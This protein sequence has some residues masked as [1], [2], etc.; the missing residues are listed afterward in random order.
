[1]DYK[2]K[3]KS[4]FQFNFKTLDDVILSSNR[5]V[6]TP[7][8]VFVFTHYFINMEIICRQIKYAFSRFI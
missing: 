3:F 4:D 1:M 8:Y 7:K 5:V 6:A 2:T